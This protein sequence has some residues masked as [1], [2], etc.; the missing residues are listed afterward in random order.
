MNAD[1]E[2]LN[3]TAAGR[4]SKDSIFRAL[5]AELHEYPGETQG[6]G[7]FGGCE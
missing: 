7:D 2:I 1:A 4:S 3:K 6:Q 5:R